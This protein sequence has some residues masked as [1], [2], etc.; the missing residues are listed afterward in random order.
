MI[1]EGLFTDEILA[2]N[3]VTIPQKKVCQDNFLATLL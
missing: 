3:N 2:N 1:L